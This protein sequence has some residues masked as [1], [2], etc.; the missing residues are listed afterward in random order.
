MADFNAKD[1]EEY[2]EGRIKDNAIDAGEDFVKECIKYYINSQSNI[3]C[4]VTYEQISVL[5]TNA[6]GDIDTF[7]TAALKNK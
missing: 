5:L 7:V 4:T 3:K 6:D 2:I 1:M